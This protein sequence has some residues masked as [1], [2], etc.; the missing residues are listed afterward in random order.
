MADETQGA[1]SLCAAA[2]R[3][4]PQAECVEYAFPL[5][6]QEL[7]QLRARIARGGYSKILVATYNLH[8]DSRQQMLLRAALSADVPVCAIAL[9]TPYDARWYEGCRA[10]MLA[11]EYTPP[12]TQAVVA[13]LRGEISCTGALP[14]DAARVL[15]RERRD[16]SCPKR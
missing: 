1:H 4:F 2:Q 15:Q 13:A 3:A 9:R 11:Y 8:A 14:D 5:S 6:E 7:A 16:L 10:W 12:M